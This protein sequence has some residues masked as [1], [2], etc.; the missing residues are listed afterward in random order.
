MPKGARTLVTILLVGDG[1]HKFTYSLA[2]G[3]AF[4]GGIPSGLSVAIAVL[5]HELPHEFGTPLY[6][7]LYRY[8]PHIY[9][10]YP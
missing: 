1:L 7:Y 5:C 2:V 8:I 4:A 9:L 6:L 3:A 10:V